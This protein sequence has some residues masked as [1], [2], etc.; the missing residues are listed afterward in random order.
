MSH[1]EDA[2]GAFDAAVT[3][4]R[5]LAAQDE[6]DRAQAEFALLTAGPEPLPAR[7]PTLIS[8]ALEL[9]RTDLGLVLLETATAC[10]AS[11]PDLA[12]ALA[13]LREELRLAE[14][15][16]PPAGSPRPQPPSAAASVEH[17]EPPLDP[18]GPEAT[19]SEPDPFDLDP[20]L[21][22]S[23]ADLVCFLH[24]FAGREG[25][26]ARQWARPPAPPTPAPA[27][28]RSTIHSR[29]PWPEPTSQ[30]A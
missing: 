26:H 3:H 11:S 29:P 24:A 7:L 1:A 28:L 10:D 6:L 21:E 23:D 12:T 17:R 25:V 20:Y 13:E 22:P 15:P 16:A 18:F 8:L 4:I 9:G 30:A 19:P 27:T 14:R 2:P 5:A